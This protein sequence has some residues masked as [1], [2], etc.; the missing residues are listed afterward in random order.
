MY[1]FHLEGVPRIFS[2]S[3][4]DHLKLTLTQPGDTVKITYVASGD[5]EV[6]I[7]KFDNLSLPLDQ[8]EASKEVEQ[9]ATV[10]EEAEAQRETVKSL[11]E[12]LRTMTPEQLQQLQK[13]L[14]K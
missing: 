10:R 6:P 4:Q 12:Q 9:A 2:G 13:S 5:G 3:S 8:T 7:Q 11:T 1:L 14:K